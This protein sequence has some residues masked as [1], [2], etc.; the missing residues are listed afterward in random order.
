MYVEDDN[1][2]VITEVELVQTNPFH[3]TAHV[4]L[5]EAMMTAYTQTVATTDKVV[6]AVK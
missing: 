2:Q 5:I 1:G 3:L 6:Q 4:S